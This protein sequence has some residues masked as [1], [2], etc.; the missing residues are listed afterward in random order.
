M[1]TRRSDRGPTAIRNSG[2]VRW[3]EYPSPLNG[4]GVS[5]TGHSELILDQFTRQ[6]LAFS[7][8]AMITDDKV[9]ARIVECAGAQPVDTVL[10]VACG[11][12]LVVCAF[13]PHVHSATGIDFTPTMLDRA[14]VL[15]AGKGIRNVAWDQG[16]AYHLPYADG[17]FSIVVTRYSLHHLL[18]PQAALREMVRVCAP[19]GR[20]V[21]VD[22]Y[23]PE[24][25]AQAAAYHRVETL[26]DPSH[27]RALSLT[28]LRELFPRAGLSNQRLRSTS[29]RSNC[30]SSSPALFPIPATRP[31]WPRYLPRPT[32]PVGSAF[33]F[34]AKPARSASPTRL[35]FSSPMREGHFQ[36]MGITGWTNR[37]GLKITPR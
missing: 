31:S 23:A 22:A 9:L 6:A 3:I 24:D 12:G 8:A 1:G 10:D 19:G 28:E 21:V 2:N 34:I 4:D 18:D 7:T 29:S 14:C 16:D 32:L 36:H 20:I 35:R 33:R 30:R 15:A 13:A 25:P 27:A 26:R 37:E 5:N 11:P 17:G